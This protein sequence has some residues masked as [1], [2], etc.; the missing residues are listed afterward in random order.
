MAFA[1]K[2][3]W[4]SEIEVYVLCFMNV[5]SREIFKIQFIYKFITL[6]GFM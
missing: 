3:S 2:K 6:Q 1:F 5:Q 4:N